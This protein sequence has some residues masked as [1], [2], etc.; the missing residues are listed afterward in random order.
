[1]ACKLSILVGAAAVLAGSTTGS[2]TCDATMCSS[3]VTADGSLGGVAVCV[4]FTKPPPPPTCLSC[5]NLCS[6][7]PCTSNC[8][9][10]CSVCLPTAV[11]IVGAC[12]EVTQGT[13]YLLTSDSSLDFGLAAALDFS[14]AF[15]GSTVVTVDSSATATV[16]GSAVVNL[17][18]S[19]AV[20]ALVLGTN[21][22]SSAIVEVN[23]SATVT[24]WTNNAGKTKVENNCSNLVVGS[25]DVGSSSLSVYQSCPKANVTISSL[26]FAASGSLSGAGKLSIAGG[27]ARINAD[28][29]GSVTGTGNVSLSGG[30][31][32]EGN[33]PASVT[34]GV[35]GSS[36]NAA[37]IS[38]DANKMFHVEGDMTADAAGTVAVYGKLAFGAATKAVQAKVIVNAGASLVFNSSSSCAA[39]AVEIAAGS[40][41]EIGANVKSNTL[42][43]GQFAKCLGVVRINLATTASAFISG[44]SAGS[45]VAFT[46]TGGNAAELSKCAVEVIDSTGAK[47]TLTSRTSVSGRRLLQSG[48]G[49]SATW[50][51]SSMTYTMGQQQQASGAFVYTLAPILVG[52]LAL[53]A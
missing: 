40:Y 45:A 3:C 33:L 48:N 41:L 30:V 9:V 23:S 10:N 43:L 46:Y 5:S 53:V 25:M 11:G 18:S 22:A 28:M 52:F 42:A 36:N 20:D 2:A 6:T 12:V 26:S 47:V 15:Q 14:L 16:S 19:T 50:S 21:L 51:D 32:I 29:S 38:I 24:L 13:G 35:Q 1:M 17:A 34:V 4:N 27:V 49:G 7:S 31:A 37:L 44:S 8:A 39:K